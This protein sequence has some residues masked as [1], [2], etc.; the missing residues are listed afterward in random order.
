MATTPPL[1]IDLT[2]QTARSLGLPEGRL[3]LRLV[4]RPNSNPFLLGLLD[5]AAPQPEIA[6]S[7]RRRLAVRI[8]RCP[9]CGREATATALLRHILRTHVDPVRP[10]PNHTARVAKKQK[11]KPAARDSRHTKSGKGSLGR[12]PSSSSPY[13]HRSKKWH[14][15]HVRHP[16]QD[17]CEQITHAGHR[18]TRPVAVRLG[19]IA[20]CN[21]HAN[22]MG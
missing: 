11:H 7:P 14:L 20:L 9:L 4:S 15:R 2:K 1:S 5:A 13:R 6:A 16:Q 19:S 10:S 21:Q 12:T 8:N 22:P 18:C 3:L 17:R